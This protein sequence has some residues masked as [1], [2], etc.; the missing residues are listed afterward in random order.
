MAALRMAHSQ[1]MRLV[2]KL[3]PLDLW[4]EMR[5]INPAT[6]NIQSSTRP[7]RRTAQIA[8]EARKALI[9]TGLL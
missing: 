5:E 7:S 3:Y 1:L 8:A 2:I 9:R 4:Q 6:E